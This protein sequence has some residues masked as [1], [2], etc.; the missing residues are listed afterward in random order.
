MMTNSTLIKGSPPQGLL[1][2]TI[3]FFFGSAAISLFGPTAKILEEV[4]QLT[5]T[6]MGLLVS[7]PILSGSLLRIPFGALVDENGGRK[8]FLLLMILSVIGLAGLSALLALNYP[9]N[10]DGKYWLI[11]FFGCLSGC[12]VATF[13]VGA[14]QSSYWYPKNKQ[15]YALGIF[16]GFGTLGAGVFAIVLPLLLNSVG[17]INAYYIWTILIIIGALV[18]GYT[19]C[20]AYYFQYKKQGYNSEK[21]KELASKDGQELFPTGNM[22]QSLINSAKFTETWILVIIYFVT[23]G[24]FIALTAWLPT[25]WQNAYGFSVT[26]AGLLT[27]IYACSAA[28]LRIPGGKISDKIGGLKVSAFSIILLGIAS[29]FIAFSSHWVISMM[30]TLFIAV[31]F[32]LN[33]A[34]TMKLVAVYVPKSVGGASGWIGGLGAFGGFILP[35]IMGKIVSVAGE[36]GYHLGFLTFTILSA[37][38][39]MILY[40][41]LIIKNKKK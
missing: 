30:C 20:N 31:A 3:G 17:F 11:L 27:A 2:A 18:Y 9:N 29:L 28:L 41:G 5:P 35:P 26:E 12:G 25:Y 16:G 15:G 10:M 39:I 7:I 14:G 6:M 1:A 4:M 8:P 21:S 13:S 24:G 23:F 40:F 22:K 33:N 19:S 37:I 38:I 32:G 34:A 36:T